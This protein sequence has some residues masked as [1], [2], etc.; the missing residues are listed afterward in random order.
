MKVKEVD[1]ERDGKI[2]VGSSVVIAEQG[3]TTEMPSDA[4]PGETNINMSHL[5]GNTDPNARTIQPRKSY[6]QN[7]ANHEKIN[8][9]E[10]FRQRAPTMKLKTQ[11]NSDPTHALG[12]Q[13]QL[14]ESQAT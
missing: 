10:D 13:A 11:E 14:N 12:I 3:A 2:D 4:I 6:D 5:S 9:K 8:F 1:L 7:L